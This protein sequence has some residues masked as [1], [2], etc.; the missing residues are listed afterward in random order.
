MQCV[1]RRQIG[2]IS[3]F[4]DPS[5]VQCR[6]RSASLGPSGV[7]AGGTTI[8]QCAQHVQESEVTRV[9][10]IRSDAPFFL[11]CAIVRATV[12]AG[13]VAVDAPWRNATCHGATNY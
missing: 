10:F 8:E 2:S 4:P 11:V 5:F 1:A 9:V 13:D 3:F 12:Q 7:V 6:P